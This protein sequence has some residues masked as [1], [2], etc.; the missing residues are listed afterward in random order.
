MGQLF[1]ES[2]IYYHFFEANVY[3]SPIGLEGFSRKRSLRGLT[4]GLTWGLSVNIDSNLTRR[5]QRDGALDGAPPNGGRVAVKTVNYSQCNK[6]FRDGPCAPP[7]LCLRICRNLRIDGAGLSDNNRLVRAI[8][9]S[10][11]SF[12]TTWY[13]ALHVRVFRKPSRGEVDT[14]L[15]LDKSECPDVSTPPRRINLSTIARF[16]GSFNAHLIPLWTIEVNLSLFHRVEAIE[17]AN[18]THIYCTH[19]LSRN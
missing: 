12:S 15:L 19:G 3:W 4:K 16:T 2:R 17:N 9:R 7:S 6:R 8:Y 13:V 11:A 1:L 18:N 5:R 10:R 14:R